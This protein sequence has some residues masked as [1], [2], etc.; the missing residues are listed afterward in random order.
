MKAHYGITLFHFLINSTYKIVFAI[1][2]VS[3]WMLTLSKKGKSFGE[4]NNF[5]SVSQN[6]LSFLGEKTPSSSALEGGGS[7]I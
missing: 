1:D 2:S 6:Y 7:S 5:A 4:S 3:L